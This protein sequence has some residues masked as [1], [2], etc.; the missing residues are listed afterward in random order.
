[1][2]KL[3][4][5]RNF[6][7]AHP[8]VAKLLVHDDERRREYSR[9]GSS[10]YAPKYDSGAE[11]RRLLIINAL[12]LAAARLGCRP[13]MSTS[14]Y[15]SE[16]GNDRDISIGVG[17]AHI[18]FTIE[19]IKSRKEEKRER[20]RLAIGS[21]RNQ[22]R[23][24]DGYEDGANGSIEDQLTEIFVQMLIRAENCY[25]MSLV[26]H[27]EWIIKQK[28][29][30]VAEIERQRQEA[31]REAREAQERLERERIARLVAQAKSLDRANQIRTYVETVRGRAPDTPIPQT[32]LDRWSAWALG[33]A[34]RIDPVKNGTIMR[35][36]ENQF[37]APM[38]ESD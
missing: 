19:P 24:P 32:D 33:E 28:A 13:S 31:E 26:R 36:I 9:Y 29:E 30:A 14:R 25:R 38:D 1:V 15:G 27:R 34:D 37:L 17:T 11:R 7:P 16:L 10:Y 23:D 6:E 3:R 4:V 2:G 18:T 20:L 8:L 12:F 21:A 5:Q 35:T 22:T